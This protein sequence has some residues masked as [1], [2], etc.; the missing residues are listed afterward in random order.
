MN[1]KKFYQICSCLS[2]AIRVE[3]HRSACPGGISTFRVEDVDSRDSNDA[4]EA[5]PG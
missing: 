3:A 2:C 4:G 1:A 5:C